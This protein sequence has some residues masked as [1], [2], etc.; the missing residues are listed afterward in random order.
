MPPFCGCRLGLKVAIADWDEENLKKVAK[1]LTAL[2][3]EANVLV[4]RTDV[5]KLEDVVALKERVYEAW[6]EVRIE[7]PL[8]A[9]SLAI[10]S[11]Y[12]PHS[13][14]LNPLVISSY[15]NTFPSTSLS[16]RDT[17][18]VLVVL[19]RHIP[20]PTLSWDWF[21]FLLSPYL[22]CSALPWLLPAHDVSHH[23]SCIHES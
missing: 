6:G 22:P 18:A 2:V 3:G 13:D 12:T 9:T 19:H 4:I 23:T 14:D 16:H 10:Y 1:E 5:S 20:L 7:I 15:E 17:T 11:Y 8:A 21:I